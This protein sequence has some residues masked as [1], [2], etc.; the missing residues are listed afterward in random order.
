MIAWCPYCFDWPIGSG[1]PSELDGRY[2]C[3]GW[4]HFGL[5]AQRRRCPEDCPVA[6]GPWG[7]WRSIV[8]HIPFDA[9]AVDA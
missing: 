5:S 9:V 8:G 4:I 3:M 6:V 7:A 2:W 1:V